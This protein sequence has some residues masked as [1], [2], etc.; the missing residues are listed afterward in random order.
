MSRLLLQPGI[1]QRVFIL[2]I[3]SLYQNNQIFATEFFGK[4][5]KITILNRDGAYSD[6]G[7]RHQQP[8]T[9][10]RKTYTIIQI[11]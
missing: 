2:L 5:N 4:K 1:S 8:L 7:H 10:A 6:S 3:P 11:K 9:T